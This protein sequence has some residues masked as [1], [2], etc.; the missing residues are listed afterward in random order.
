MPLGT[1]PLGI[2]R[3]I[4]VILF[5]LRSISP[6]VLKRIYRNTWGWVRHRAHLSPRVNGKIAGESIGYACSAVTGV[7]PSSDPFRF[8]H[9]ELNASAEI[10][11]RSLVPT[12][13][14]PVLHWLEMVSISSHPEIGYRSAPPVTLIASPVI[15]L[16]FSLTNI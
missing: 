6:S 3:H 12:L 15:K 14:R 8:V 11:G 1:Q 5:Y 9:G 16:A 13:E 10:S 4:S 7:L 2:R